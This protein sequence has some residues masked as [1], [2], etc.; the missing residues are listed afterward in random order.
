MSQETLEKERVDLGG[1]SDETLLQSLKGGG[2]PPALDVTD[3][4]CQFNAQR[5]PVIQVPAL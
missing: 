5:N 1:E 3:D 2:E 4:I